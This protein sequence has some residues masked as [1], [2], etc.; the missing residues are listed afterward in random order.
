LNANNGRRS[1]WDVAADQI[2]GGVKTQLYLPGQHNTCATRVSY[3]LNYSNS[4]IPLKGY[5][6]KG[7]DNK[8][9]ILGATKML[10]YLKQAYGTNSTNTIHL[11][12]TSSQPLTEAYIQSQLSGHQGIYAIVANDNSQATGFGATGHVD[13]LD[14][15]GT[16]A[17]G[18]SYWYCRGGVKEVYLFIL[19]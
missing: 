14:S 7:A 8:N 5:T 18:H 19:N 15:N 16:F 9:Y 6:F 2:G 10:S 11:V 3:A 17:S 12:G 1:T 13:L 4:P